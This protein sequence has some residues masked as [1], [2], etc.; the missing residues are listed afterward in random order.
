MARTKKGTSLRRKQADHDT[1]L[2]D[3]YEKT[4]LEQ[5][6]PM[7]FKLASKFSTDLIPF[8]DL[9]QIA[10]LGIAAAFRSFNGGSDLTYWLWRKGYHAI[11]DA[12][13]S[14]SRRVQRNPQ[15]SEIGVSMLESSEKTGVE[16]QI[17]EDEQNE[18]QAELKILR[19]KVKE[20]SEP[21]RTIVE[22]IGLKGER[23]VDVAKELG[24][25][26]SYVS[27]FYAAGIEQ[28]KRLYFPER[29]ANEPKQL[30]LFEL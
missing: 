13:R 14:E 2:L 11:E 9:Q 28:L 8:E 7:S 1:P 5:Y 18:H 20:L 26:Q 21:Y 6:V 25:S 24:A 3:W 22:K 27:R 23:Q 15:A 30:L 4:T 17:E 10:F 29:Y 19:E 16:I 12:I